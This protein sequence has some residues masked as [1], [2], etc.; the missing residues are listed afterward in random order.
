LSYKLCGKSIFGDVKFSR[1][2]S[3]LLSPT[4]KERK[5]EPTIIFYILILVIGKGP[6][7]APS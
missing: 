3:H 7:L 2:A 4:A 6:K 1:F 5:S